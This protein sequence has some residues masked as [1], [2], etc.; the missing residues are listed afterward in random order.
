MIFQYFLIS[1]QSNF[2]D[3]RFGSKSFIEMHEGL[4]PGYVGHQE[5]V[6]PAFPAE[7]R[8]GHGGGGLADVCEDNTS[9]GTRVLCCGV[10]LVMGVL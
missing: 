6:K 9:C 3:K 4:G 5:L 1:F 7:P 2:E 8:G 10:G